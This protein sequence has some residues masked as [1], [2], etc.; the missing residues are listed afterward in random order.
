[1]LQREDIAQER[2]VLRQDQNDFERQ[3]GRLEQERSDLQ[4]ERAEL[5]RK[6]IALLR[7][8]GRLKDDRADFAREK[9]EWEQW[10]NRGETAEPG[11]FSD[12]SSFHS[13][14]PSYE[15]LPLVPTDE[16]NESHWYGWQTLLLDGGVFLAGV[17]VK[18]PELA[19]TGVLLGGASIHLLHGRWGKALLSAGLGAGLGVGAVLVTGNDDSE[20]DQVTAVFAVGA[21]LATL[22]DVFVMARGERRRSGTLTLVPSVAADGRSVR[23]G[24]GGVF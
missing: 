17:V 1:M 5:S 12:S 4:R 6:R 3:K 20:P 11:T 18:S 2:E 15:P 9:K 7:D 24:I 10:K 8:R 13:T 16:Q 23:V 22:F 21:G 19:T 14:E